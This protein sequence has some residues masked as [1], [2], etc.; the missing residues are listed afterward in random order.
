M[1]NVRPDILSTVE[2]IMSNVGSYLESR[3]V[4]TAAAMA[5]AL[6]GLSVYLFTENH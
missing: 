5:A 2:D 1:I 4:G 6:F 3:A